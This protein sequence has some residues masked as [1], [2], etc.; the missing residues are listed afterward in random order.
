MSLAGY[1]RR[2][3]PWIGKHLNWGAH[4]LSPEVNKLVTVL[5]PAQRECLDFPAA[6]HDYW[7]EQ[8]IGD[9]QLRYPEMDMEPYRRGLRQAAGS[10]QAKL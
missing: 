5:T 8:T 10:G 6:G 2:D 7:N 3:A 9:V 4:G 1:C